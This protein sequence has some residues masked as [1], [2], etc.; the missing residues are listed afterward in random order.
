MRHVIGQVDAALDQRTN[1]IANVRDLH[2]QL[3][4]AEVHLHA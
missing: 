2:A 3:D 4:R 1:T